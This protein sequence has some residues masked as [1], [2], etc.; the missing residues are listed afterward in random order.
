MDPSRQN[1]T[2]SRHQQCGASPFA[3]PVRPADCA[4][5][6]DVDGTL[7]EIAPTPDDVVVPPRLVALLDRLHRA[8]AGAVAL[9]SGRAIDRIDALFAPLSMPAAGQHGAQLRLTTMDSFTSATPASVLSDLYRRLIEFADAHPG[10]VVEAKGLS[11]AAHYRQ[12]PQ[13][14]DALAALLA[15]RLTAMG[16][17]WQLLPGKMVFEVKPRHITKGTAVEWFMRR[18]PFA[19]RTPIF[20]GDDVTDEDGFAAALR[21]GGASASVGE[22]IAGRAGFADPAAL[23]AWLAA[24]ADAAEAS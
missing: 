3:L 20:V 1:T 21:L 24:L 12:Q 17:G 9:V 4:L 22:R 8:L 15:E 14:R 13:G 23:H 5:F 16:P 2:E 10:V 19:G 7:L 11:I 6:L 18:P